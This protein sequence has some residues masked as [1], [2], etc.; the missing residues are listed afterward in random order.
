MPSANASYCRA[1]SGLSPPSCCP[2]RAHS[3]IKK[4]YLPFMRQIP[5]FFTDSQVHVVSLP[6]L[7]G[8][9]P[10]PRPRADEGQPCG[11]SPFALCFS[12]AHPSSGPAGPPSPTWRKA[13]L[14]PIHGQSPSGHRCRAPHFFAPSFPCAK[15]LTSHPGTGAPMAAAFSAME[16]SSVKMYHTSTTRCV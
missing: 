5:F 9:C 13:K 15:I 11:D 14:P 10:R 8:R 3:K 1:R 2:C 6:P 4:G 7:G 12:Q 16:P